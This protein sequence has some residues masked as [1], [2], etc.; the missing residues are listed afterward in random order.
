MSNLVDRAQALR[1][2]QY[3]A[4]SDRVAGQMALHRQRRSGQGEFLGDMIGGFGQAVSQRV[5]G[6]VMRVLPAF[7]TVMVGGWLVYLLATAA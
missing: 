3:H 5:M 7:N 6:H 4:Q 1:E 2:Q